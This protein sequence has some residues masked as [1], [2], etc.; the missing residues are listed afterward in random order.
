MARGSARAAVPQALGEPVTAGGEPLGCHYPR[1]RDRRHRG[2]RRRRPGRTPHVRRREP[3]SAP[4]AG[5]S[6]GRF[7]RLS[8][9]QAGTRPSEQAPPFVQ[10]ISNEAERTVVLRS[11]NDPAALA[12]QVRAIFRAIPTRRRPGQ[13]LGLQRVL[14]PD[15]NLPLR[16][17]ALERSSDA[18]DGPGLKD[19]LL[20]LLDFEKMEEI[21]GR[22]IFATGFE[23]GTEYMHASAGA[24][25]IGITLASGFRRPG[26]RRSGGR[27]TGPTAEPAR[28]PAQR[29]R[30]AGSSGR[31]RSG[32]APRRS[33][34]C[35]RSRA[36]SRS[37]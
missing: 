34:R 35:R 5:G 22:I 28:G 14:R 25:R 33:S 18:V 11:A 12:M 7:L 36:R 21:R 9:A 37:R 6:A 13:V 15:R 27:P 3:S 17:S 19:E 20:E 8:P 23:V 10:K 29:C 2:P 24:T 26:T 30:R 31:D 32:R 1:P 16:Q 4:T